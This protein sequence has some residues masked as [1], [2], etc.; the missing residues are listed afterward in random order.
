MQFNPANY[1]T[2]IDWS[3]AFFYIAI[4]TLFLWFWKSMK[5]GDDRAY[6]WF[7]PALLFKFFGGICILMIY[8]YYYKGGDTY[9]YFENTKVLIRLSSEDAGAVARFLLGENSPASWLKFTYDSGRPSFDLFSDGNAWAVSRFSFPFVV[10]GAGRI[11]SSVIVLNTFAFIGP[12]KFFYFLNK[13]YPGFTKRIAVAV[14]FIPSCVFWGSGLYKDTFTLSATLWLFYS[15]MKIALEKKK[16]AVNLIMILFNAYVVISIKPYIF[17][18][19]LPAAMIIF[20]YSSVQSIRS[21][22][23]RVL[24]LPLST[25]V[26]FVSGFSIYSSLSTSLGRYG[27]MDVMMEKLVVTR[28][29]FINNKTYSSNFFDIGTFEPTLGGVLSKAP[30]AFTYGLFGPFVWHVANPVMAISAIEGVVF[31][32]L[33]LIALRNILFRKGNLKVLSDPVIIGF[34]LF[35]VVFI[36]FVGISTANFGSMVRYRIPALPLMIFALLFIQKKSK[37]NLNKVDV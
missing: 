28:E 22:V 19:L 29:D 21:K 9:S 8:G 11:L 15:I 18:A 31:L 33:F 25:V 26:V 14:F 5:K 13:R 27:D 20:L 34:L 6:D 35:S 32:L 30:I 36:V 10:V 7:I 12:W 1:I 37:S 3:L 2:W 23:L 16:V 24:I 4:I 17:V